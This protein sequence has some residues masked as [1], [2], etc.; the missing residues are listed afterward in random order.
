MTDKTDNGS[1]AWNAAIPQWAVMQWTVTG[2]TT[3]VLQ[4]FALCATVLVF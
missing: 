1:G 2:A 3:T 4:A